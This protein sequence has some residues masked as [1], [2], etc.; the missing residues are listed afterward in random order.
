LP[1]GRATVVVV[2][3]VEQFLALGGI[4]RQRSALGHRGFLLSG[5]D[6]SMIPNLN[7]NTHQG[8]KPRR[9]DRPILPCT[10]APRVPGL[11]QCATRAPPPPPRHISPSPTPP[12]MRATA[13]GYGCLTVRRSRVR[14]RARPDSL[15]RTCEDTSVFSPLRKLLS[16]PPS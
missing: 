12:P 16:R 6:A 5:S 4:Q 2:T 15:A 9:S 10:A 13:R 7:V 3:G 11:I 8:M 14:R 1:Y